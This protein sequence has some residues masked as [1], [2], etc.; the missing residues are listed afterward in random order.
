MSDA[1]TEMRDV[2]LET[3][4]IAV[5]GASD[6]PDRAAHGVMRFLQERGYRCIPVSPRLAGSEL[7]GETV[8]ASLSDIPE[9]FDMADLFVNSSLA[10]DIT[11]EAIA[12]GAKTVWMQLGVVDEAA[13][14]RARDAGVRV[15]MDHCPA[16]EWAGLDLPDRIDS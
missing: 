11:D 14:Q 3:R 9:P 16:Q 5:V 8:Y 13:A 2:L 6:K 1:R 12:A 7:L 4:T 15:I 10:G